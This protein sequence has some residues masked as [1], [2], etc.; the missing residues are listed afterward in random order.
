MKE[1]QTMTKEGFSMSDIA[2]NLAGVGVVAAIIS[3]A[4]QWIQL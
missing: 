1:E 2:M 3:A 4:V